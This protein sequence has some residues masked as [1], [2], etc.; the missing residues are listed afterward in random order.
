[1][2][3]QTIRD[4]FPAFDLAPVLGARLLPSVEVREAILWEYGLSELLPFAID[5]K[6]IDL[7]ALDFVR[8]RGTLFSIRTALRW[9]GF[10]DVKFIRLL[11]SEYELDSGRVPSGLETKG[12]LAV[13]S[14]SVQ[15]RGHCKRIYSG[16]FSYEVPNG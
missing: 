7:E 12:I 8:L 13:L 10:P 2:I 1:M 15:K 4:F 16:S 11:G 6:V 14:V 3:E 5:P 9:V